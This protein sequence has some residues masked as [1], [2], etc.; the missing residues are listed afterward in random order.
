MKLIEIASCIVGLAAAQQN[1]DNTSD[2]PRP[3]WQPTT[4]KYLG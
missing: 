3:D 4:P 2:T 1:T